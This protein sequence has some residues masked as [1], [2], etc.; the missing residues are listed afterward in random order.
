[1]VSSG[2]GLLDGDGVSETFELGDESLGC[3]L[4]IALGEVVGAGFAVQLAVGQDVP[5]RAK[6]RVLDRAESP[7]VSIRE[8]WR[9]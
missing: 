6:D 4:G 1:L 9:S 5:G 8:R 7:A 3:A 2:G